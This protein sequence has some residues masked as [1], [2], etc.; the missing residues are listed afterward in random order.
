MIPVF[1]GGVTG[2]VIAWV[3]LDRGY[4]VVVASKERASFGNDRKLNSWIAGTLLTINTYI[5]RA[6]WR[7]WLLIVICNGGNLRQQFGVSTQTLSPSTGPKKK[8]VHTAYQTWEAIAK[9]PSLEPDAGVQ[10]RKSVFFLSTSS[11]TIQSSC[12]KCPKYTAA[13]SKG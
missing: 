10:M 2:F 5:I 1:G 13:V 12:S 8:M 7:F 3:L 6:A 11:S 9:D 4:N